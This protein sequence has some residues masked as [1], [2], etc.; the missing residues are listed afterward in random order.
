M[1]A[2]QSKRPDDWQLPER[3]RDPWSVS[4]FMFRTFNL[5]FEWGWTPGSVIRMMGPYGPR[6]VQG[7]ARNRC[8]AQE[9]TEMHVSLRGMAGKT[10]QSSHR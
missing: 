8:V 7:Y 3:L 2:L 1:H 4:G 9:R 6:L 10:G 5:A